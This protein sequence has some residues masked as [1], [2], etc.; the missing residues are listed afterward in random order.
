MKFHNKRL[1]A[2]ACFFCY[3][4]YCEELNTRARPGE[5]PCLAFLIN[6][7]FKVGVY[8]FLHFRG[9]AGKQKTKTNH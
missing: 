9:R 1:P 8:Y 7:N 4:L 3:N 6:F 2:I 5:N